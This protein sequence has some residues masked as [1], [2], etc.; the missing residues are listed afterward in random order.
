MNTCSYIRFNIVFCIWQK[1]GE[2]MIKE[3]AETFNEKSNKK[4]CLC[5][6]SKRKSWQNVKT[7]LVHWTNSN[8]HLVPLKMPKRSPF[9]ESPCLEPEETG[10]EVLSH[11]LVNQQDCQEDIFFPLT[12][13]LNTPELLLPAEFNHIHPLVVTLFLAEIPN[14]P[15]ARRL[16]YYLRNWKKLTIDPIMSGNRQNLQDP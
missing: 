15:K 14:L 8:H 6:S 2:S 5:R 11:R 7:F 4:H 13:L 12:L 10:G 1:K 16:K 3:N 9:N